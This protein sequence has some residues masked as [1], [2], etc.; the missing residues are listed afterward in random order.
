MDCAAMY[1]D[2]TCFIITPVG[3]N[4]TPIRRAAD[5]LISAVI[6]PVLK[7]MG[8]SG[9]H[10]PHELP[11]PGSITSQVIKYIINDD[12]VIANLTGLNPNVMY[13]VSLRHAAR[14]PLVIM[15]E[16]ETALP[17]DINDQRAIFYKNDMA[18]AVEIKNELVKKVQAAI[19]DTNIDNP[20][21]KVVK[22]N[23]IE[24]MINQDPTA[25]IPAEAVLSRME[26]FESGLNEVTRTLN[27][28]INRSDYERAKR[29]FVSHAGERI[30]DKNVCF[31][32]LRGSLTV[33]NNNDSD[34]E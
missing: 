28:M 32:E 23:M 3:A 27:R 34:T 13:E 1:S 7:E 2:K 12:L 26:S 4:L 24:K 30:K 14:K 20:I 31:G 21:Y 25:T 15:C 16:E 33:T 10:V 9:I 18:G 5:G 19:S 11:D 6:K 29:N 22:D 17:F 8:F